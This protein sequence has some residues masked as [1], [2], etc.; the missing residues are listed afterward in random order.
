MPTDRNAPEKSLPAL[1]LTLLVAAGGAPPA[2]GA[3]IHPHSQ[4]WPRPPGSA[5]MVRVPAGEMLMGDGEAACGWQQ[6]G[7][8]LSHD[9]WIQAHEVSNEEFR[10]AL[11]WAHDLGLVSATPQ[12]VH[13]AM[14]SGE[15]LVDLDDDECELA[16]SGGIFTLRQ[17]D[18]ALEHAYPQGYDPGPH[19]AKEVTWYGAASYCDWL[20]LRCGLSPAYDH[21]D[22][23]CGPQGVPYRAA[24]FRLPTDAEWEYVA[25][26]ADQRIYPWG[27]AE[28]DCDL[29]NHD[30]VDSCIR[31]TAPVDSH[32]AG[33]QNTLSRPIH[34]ISGN[35]YEWI[36]DWF[37]CSLGTAPVRDPIGPPTG[38]KRVI[39]GGGWYSHP[40][41]TR[42]AARNSDPP[43]FSAGDVGLRPVRSIAP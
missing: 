20:S 43:D 30:G 3:E 32:A 40:R 6:R 29:A 9:F 28:P 23:S 12:A 38:V 18:Y 41:Y 14:G 25:R 22:W 33:A 17:S 21:A 11:Q 15:E 36:H 16:F 39:R 13:D 31:W 5:G 24:G 8:R 2:C 1:A 26:F 7:V 10:S 37:T 34:H 35:V 27:D 4:E 42:A 19:P